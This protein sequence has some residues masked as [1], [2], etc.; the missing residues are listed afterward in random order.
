MRISYSITMGHTMLAPLSVSQ[1]PT[2]NSFAKR[3]PERTRITLKGS[4]HLAA[5]PAISQISD[6]ALTVIKNNCICFLHTNH[7]L[8][9]I[10]DLIHRPG[11]ELMVQAVV[12]P[13]KAAPSRIPQGLFCH[14][15]PATQKS[16]HVGGTKPGKFTWGSQRSLRACDIRRQKA[17][18]KKAG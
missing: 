13:V 12:D 11:S 15:S 6:K 14:H 3:T 5:G 16:E 8:R 1:N 17:G 9:R 7:L 4:Y 18:E 10:D 2:H